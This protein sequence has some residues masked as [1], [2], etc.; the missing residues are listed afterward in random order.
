M[1]A[2]V[3]SSLLS[4]GNPSGE[5]VTDLHTGFPIALAEML[6]DNLFILPDL[7]CSISSMLDMQD[8]CG[9]GLGEHGAIGQ[10]GE[11]GAPWLK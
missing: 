2:C 8:L 5:V 7:E 6:K 9:S 3:S 10:Q 1:C 4:S 11:H